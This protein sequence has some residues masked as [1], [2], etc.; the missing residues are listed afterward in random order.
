MLVPELSD[1]LDTLPKYQ[2]T[3]K[4][5][6]SNSFMNDV[7]EL[8]LELGTGPNGKLHKCVFQNTLAH[9]T[10]VGGLR[11]GNFSNKGRV[12]SMK[13]CQDLCCND[14]KCDVAVMMKQS[15]F[16]VAC[17]SMELCQP[18]AAKLERFSLLL[19]YRDRSAEK[20]GI[21]SLLI[22]RVKLNIVSDFNLLFSFLFNYFQFFVLFFKICLLYL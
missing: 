1:A 8:E 5:G 16:L 20:E 10:F 22:Q 14:F 4:E 18:R 6:S 7:N 3:L 2:P 19:S 11:A 13:T 15:C 12:T 21:L 17:N 9:T